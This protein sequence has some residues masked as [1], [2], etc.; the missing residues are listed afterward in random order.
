MSLR[1]QFFDGKAAKEASDDVNVALK[2]S[3]TIKIVVSRA[4]GQIA[5]SLLPLLCR[6]LIFGSSERLEIRLLD[7]PEAELA[8]LGV[9]MELEDC[10]FT[11]TESILSTSKLEIAFRD[12]DV[13]LLLGGFP[14]KEGM[15]RCVMRFCVVIFKAQGRV[16]ETYAN[17]D[18]K[19]L[20]VANPANT[21]CWITMKH[22]PRIARRNLIALTRLDQER[23]RAVLCQRLN[24]N[25]SFQRNSP[26]DVSK[27]IIWGNHSNTQ[28]P[29][30]TF[31]TFH[32]PDDPQGEQQ[33]SEEVAE[34]FSDII[35]HVRKREASVLQARKLSSAISAASAIAPH[36]KDWFC[37]NQA[38]I[39][40]KELISMGVCSDDNKYGIPCDL[41]YSFP[42]RCLCNGEYQIVSDLQVS[43]S[44]QSDM[45]ASA[46]ELLLEKNQ[47][48]EMVSSPIGS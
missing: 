45:N 30:C 7:I 5:Y 13:A 23:L 14:R 32:L 29:D 40:N 3:M 19:V 46:E 38:S 24:G 21:N 2:S 1:W 28:V 41:I 42:V 10:T 25:R 4:A 39:N 11:L 9:K 20:V 33:V 44:I 8:L 34:C 22:A 43:S 47:A 48:L 6:G 27:C 18:V 17:E 26:F 36:L 12:V 15:Q 35:A 37:G 31:A 16:L